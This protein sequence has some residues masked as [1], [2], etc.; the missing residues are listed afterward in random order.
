MSVLNVAPQKHFCEEVEQRYMIL[1]VAKNE[2]FM[3][4]IFWWYEGLEERQVFFPLCN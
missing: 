3:S 4:S 1:N 2:I